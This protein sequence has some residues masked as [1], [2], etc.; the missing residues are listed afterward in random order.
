VVLIGG[1]AGDSCTV[2]DCVPLE[3]GSTT[4]EYGLGRL[5]AASVAPAR[6]STPEAF[7]D[8]PCIRRRPRLTPHHFLGRRSHE[9]DLTARRRSR[10]HGRSRP[11]SAARTSAVHDKH[12]PDGR[13]RSAAFH[14]L[15]L[16]P[17]VSGG[18]GRSCLT[19]TPGGATA[20][21]RVPHRLS[22]GRLALDLAAVSRAWQRP[23][24]R[25]VRPSRK[26][27][28]WRARVSRRAAPRHRF[29]GYARGGGSAL[30]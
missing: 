16:I 1:R 20:L 21:P 29:G 12:S 23:R 10:C 11:R 15:R 30:P 3:A 7:S 17:V 4:T 6:R 9:R 19:G 13:Q 25:P 5:C 18:R 14:A 8:R 22:L 28:R 24:G 27:H 2:V 26:V